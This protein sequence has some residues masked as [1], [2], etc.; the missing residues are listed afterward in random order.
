GMRG[1]CDA[2]RA[3]VLRKAGMKT[4]CLYFAGKFSG[5]RRNGVTDVGVLTRERRKFLTESDHVIDHEH[6][7]VASW[8]GLDAD[9][10]D[11]YGLRDPFCQIPRHVL[12]HNQK[13]TRFG[14]ADCLRQYAIR[15]AGF[16]SDL[17]EAG[18][19]LRCE[20]KVPDDLHAMIDQMPDD[21]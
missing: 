8:A 2:R 11:V 17:F 7:S 3:T 6:L 14:N 16:Q 10:R 4:F 12:E 21:F 13:G 1:G 9:G 19:R 18:G 5:S 15:L 20:T